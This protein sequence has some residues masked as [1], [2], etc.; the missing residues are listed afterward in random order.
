MNNPNAGDYNP[1]QRKA[2]YKGRYPG[3]RYKDKEYRKG[4][5]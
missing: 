2:G 5:G 4:G 3:K 1:H